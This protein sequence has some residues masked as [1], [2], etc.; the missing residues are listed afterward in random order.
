MSIWDT[1]TGR[2][3]R[4]S[5]QQRSVVMQQRCG[6]FGLRY[7]VGDPADYIFTI[8]IYAYMDNAHPE[9]HLGWWRFELP[10]DA[11]QASV[12][13]DIDLIR[14]ESMTLRVGG[15]PVPSQDQWHNPDYAF[16]PLGDLQ[17]VLRSGSGEIQRMEPVLL[18][19]TDRD[20]LREFYVRQYTSEGYTASTDAPF[21]HEL[22]D[23]KLGRLRE[24]FDRYIP[25]GGRAIDVG[26]GRSLFTE[27]DATFRMRLRSTPAI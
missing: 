19:F 9:R 23:Y 2:R 21:L 7:T 12:E 14:A 11:G 22:H 5:P 1:I 18:K 6:C 24:L 13:M 20:I 25:A 16:D 10:R 27:I 15:A 8:D 3:A 17:L 4:V 26:C